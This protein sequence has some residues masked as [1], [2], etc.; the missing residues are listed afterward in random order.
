MWLVFLPSQIVAKSIFC[1]L[2]ALTIWRINSFW[3]LM[4][5]I[6]QLLVF[7]PPIHL[8]N[9][10]ST[11]VSLSSV[12]I[13]AWCVYLL[14]LCDRFRAVSNKG[15]EGMRINACWQTMGWLRTNFQSLS[16]EIASDGW[17][18]I[19]SHRDVGIT[20]ISTATVAIIAKIVFELV[21]NSTLSASRIG[22]RE[23]E[24]KVIVLWFTLSAGL[25]A[26]AA[27]VTEFRW[28]KRSPA[29]CRLFLRSGLASQLDSEIKAI[30]RHKRK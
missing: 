17:N 27:L 9:G 22:M 6:F 11:S 2:I 19:K 30:H 23:S 12:F 15:E 24:L 10:G 29:V 8:V 3:L 28:R 26:A 1:A 5:L 25:A 20:F 4:F 7:E 16:M 21:P 18:W 14:V 13:G